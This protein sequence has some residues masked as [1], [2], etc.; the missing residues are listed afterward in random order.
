MVGEDANETI[1]AQLLLD[2]KNLSS[3]G[4]NEILGT[5]FI[6]VGSDGRNSAGSQFS[7]GF[8]LKHCLRERPLFTNGC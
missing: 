4:W 6:R 2:R 8:S 7:A 3:L 5:P 1:A